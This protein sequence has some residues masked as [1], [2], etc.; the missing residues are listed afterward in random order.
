MKE[1]GKKKKVQ[2]ASLVCL[3]WEVSD[4]PV[5]NKEDAS[6]LIEQKAGLEKRKKEAE[7]LA[8]QKETERDRRIRIIG[9]YVHDS[10]PVSNNEVRQS[11][12]HG[13]VDANCHPVGIG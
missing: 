6:D 5:Q 1:I 4:S 12:H 7:E 8:V 10:V 9:N 2:P 13:A 3:G 11:L